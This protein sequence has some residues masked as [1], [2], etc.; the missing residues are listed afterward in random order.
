MRYQGKKREPCTILELKVSL[1]RN[2]WQNNT[3]PTECSKNSRGTYEPTTFHNINVDDVPVPPNS[4][5]YRRHNNTDTFTRVF[6]YPFIVV[7]IHNVIHGTRLQWKRIGFFSP[8]YGGYYAYRKRF[9]DPK[10]KANI[11]KPSSCRIFHFFIY[12][13]SKPPPPR[14]RRL[15]P[16]ADTSA[17]YLR[18]FLHS[19]CRRQIFYVFFYFPF[20]VSLAIELTYTVIVRVCRLALPSTL[21]NAHTRTR[22]HTRASL[23]RYGMYV[24]CRNTYGGGIPTAV[25]WP[26]H[27]G[28]LYN[29]TNRYAC[30]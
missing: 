21:P 1:F 8:V 2:I 20:S 22:T 25:P 14:V 16:A 15:S 13:P 12:G 27:N 28:G 17:Y 7:V 4:I 10:K 9:V 29:T 23:P 11:K 3:K 5:P 19:N 30:V 24:T 18:T 6:I 26:H